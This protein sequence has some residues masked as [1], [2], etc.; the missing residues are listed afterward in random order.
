MVSTSPVLELFS[1]I[2]AVFLRTRAVLVSCF[3]MRL[4]ALQQQWWWRQ[5]QTHHF[6]PRGVVLEWSLKVTVTIFD[7]L[8][9]APNKG[10]ET[11]RHP[12][13]NVARC[14][15]PSYFSPDP[16]ELSTILSFVGS[17]VSQQVSILPG[18]AKTPHIMGNK[19]SH[20]AS[21][22]EYGAYT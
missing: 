17:T 21:R 11:A 14:T 20:R 13:I 19:L 5:R 7:A 2:H 12:E 4:G 1:P 8:S 16:T 9:E 3:A 6:G 10:R 22:T 15:P 18:R